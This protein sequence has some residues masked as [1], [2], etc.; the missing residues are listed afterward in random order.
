MQ[1]AREKEKAVRDVETKASGID[2]AVFDLK[3]VNP[4]AVTKVD[5]RTPEE[6]IENIEV[7]GQIITEALGR[8]KTL[9]TEID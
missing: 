8:L 3:A 1:E 9:L 2:A 6:I 5:T 7:Q 4:N